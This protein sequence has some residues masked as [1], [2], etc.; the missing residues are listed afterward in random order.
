MAQRC[1]VE[2]LAAKLER[3]AADPAFRATLAARG[4]S[5]I[6]TTFDWVRAVDRLEALFARAA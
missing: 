6:R 1:D 4:E 5:F 2:D 3:L